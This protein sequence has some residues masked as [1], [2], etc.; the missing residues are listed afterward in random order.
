MTPEQLHILQH[1]LGLDQYSQGSMYRNRY[2]CDPNPEICALVNLGWMGDNGSIEM[3]GGMHCYYVTDEGKAAMFAA[4]PKPPKIS[5]SRERYLRFLR[6]DS[7]MNFGEW[8]KK[9]EPL[10][11]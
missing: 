8:L 2:V 7:G 10:T 11:R 1:S 4:T 9:V 5:R 3:F 6:A